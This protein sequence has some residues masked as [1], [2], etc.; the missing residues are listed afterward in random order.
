MGCKVVA[1]TE[2]GGAA[3]ID[4][5]YNLVIEASGDPSFFTFHSPELEGYSGTGH[6]V[7]ECIYNAR[8]TMP[9]F[10]AALRKDE[11]PVPIRPVSPTIVIQ[12]PEPIAH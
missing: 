12:N 5:P 2:H 8:R 11:R 10:V 6:S 4:L 9:E 1:K 7:E 3:M